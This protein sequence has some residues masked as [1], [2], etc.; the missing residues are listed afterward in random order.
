MNTD[1]NKLQENWYLQRYAVL[2]KRASKASKTEP[3]DQVYVKRLQALPNVIEMPFNSVV[4]AYIEM[5]YKQR[6]QLVEK[7]LGMSLYYMPIFEEALER[8]QMPLELKYLPIVES[9][10]DPNA[11]SKAGATGLWQ[12]MPAT[13]TGEGLEVNSLVDERRDPL[14]SSEAAA[15][16]LQKLYDTFGDWTLAIAAYNCGPG[17]VSKAITRSGGKTDYWEIYPF[18]P[19]ETRGY[20]PA[21]IAANYIMNYYAEHGISHALARRPLVTDTVH[22]TQPIYFQQISEVLDLPID[23][24]R[25]LNPQYRKDMIPGNIRPYTLILPSAQAYC[26]VA[27]A[28]SIYNHDL[29]KYSPRAYAEPNDGSPRGDGGGQYVEQLVVKKHTVKKGETLK[30]IATHYGV[31]VES[32]R[33]ANNLK[34]NKVKRGAVLKINTYER[35]AVAA[36]S[37][38]AETPQTPQPQAEP[39]AEVKEQTP[40]KTQET[41]PQNNKKQNTKADNKKQNT[42]GAKTTTYT[43]KKGDSLYKIATAHGITVKKLQQANNLKNNNIQPG[44]KLKI[45]K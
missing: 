7:M 40:A 13:A 28:D 11:V 25:V 31:T 36:D 43:V 2:D 8:H 15:V 1:I 37:V 22:V 26:F 23:E 45:P 44:Q 9:A 12:F 5:Y 4:K 32:I 29:N 34:S 21:F 38:K 39:V 14:A 17:N 33:K 20:V 30:S 42:K 27:N 35:T 19:Q 41:K 3:T 16:Y 24:I 6:P 10:L 18:L